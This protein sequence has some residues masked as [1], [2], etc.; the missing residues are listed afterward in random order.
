MHNVGGFLFV[1]YIH[2]IIRTTNRAI[3]DCIFS[4]SNSGQ[5]NQQNNPISLPT[6]GA[7]ERRRRSNGVFN[8]LG[9]SDTREQNQDHHQQHQHVRTDGARNS[10]H[11]T[12]ERQQRLEQQQETQ[13]ELEAYYSHLTED[14]V[15]ECGLQFVNYNEDQQERVNIDTNITR[16]RSHYGVDHKAITAMIKDLPQ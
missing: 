8:N 16:F 2:F 11:K 13:T 5:N 15:L 1:I 3:R 10:Q 4:I 14:R 7:Y 9:P 12:N 6:N